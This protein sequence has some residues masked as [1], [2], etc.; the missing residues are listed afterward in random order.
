[1]L[2]F[3]KDKLKGVVDKFTK[4]IDETG[5]EDISEVKDEPI[6]EANEEVSEDVKEDSLDEANEE[7]SE[8]VKEDSLDEVKEEVVTEPELTPPIEEKGFFSRLKEKFTGE[9]KKDVILERIKKEHT[10]EEEIIKQDREKH[11]QEK[12]I[13][14]SVKE[15]IHKAKKDIKNNNIEEAREEIKEAT[16][17]IETKP[18]ANEILEDVEKTQERIKEEVEQVKEDISN[19]DVSKAKEDL[20]VLNEDLNS[21]EDEASGFLGKLKQKIVTKK[22]NDEQFETMFWDL[23]VSL[24]ENNVAVQVIDKIKS[25]LRSALVDKPIKR[26]MIERT[27]LSSLK[28]SIDELFIDGK[29]IIELVKEKN[30]Y[31]ICFVGINGSGKTTTIAKVANM[32][33]KNNLSCVMAAGDTFRAA[34]I[35]QLKEHAENLDIKFISHD[36]GSDAAAVAFDAIEYAKSKKI[37]CVL[38]DT[39]G[40]LHSNVNLMEELKKLIR[41]SNPD[42]KLFVGEAITGNDCVEQAEQF[43]NAVGIDGIILAKADIDDKGGAS[44]S[45]SFITQ[46]PIYFLGTGQKYDDLKEFNKDIIINSLGLE[47]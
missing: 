22:I 16:T 13:I 30:P 42:L 15:D 37:D 35:E 45:V 46:K 7:V 29:K 40:R 18:T 27:I 12:V 1:M 38:I 10:V 20:K 5:E 2:G 4:T 43:N 24:L 31:V 23:E 32:L 26:S 41:V 8:E 21:V 28:S 17:K 25:R 34:A 36:Y 39:A 33:K 9:P 11:Q 14:K 19:K 47:V 6:D 3:L 44:I